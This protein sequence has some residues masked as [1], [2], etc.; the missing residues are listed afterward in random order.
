M[1]LFNRY[2][3]L[4]GLLLLFQCAALNAQTTSGY[5]VTKKIKLGGEGGWDYLT[6][7]AKGNRV[8]IS[9]STHVM[10]VDADTGAVVGDIPETAGVHGIALVQDMDKGYTS[11][12]RTS[13]VTVFDLKTL[14]VLKQIPVGKNPDAIIYDPASKRVFTMNGAGSDATAIDVKTDT[15]AGTVALDGKPEFAAADEKGHVFVNLEDKS[16]V[17][18]MDSQKLSVMNRWPLAP[19]EEPSGMAIDTKHHR[20]FIGCG[21]NKLM[22]VVDSESGKVITTLPTGSGVDANGFDPGT[23]FAF[24]SNGDG[25]LTIVHED[26]ADKFSVVDNV[27]TQRGAR[28]MT[29]DT[30]THRVFLVTADFGPPPPAT[31]ERPRPRPSVVPG[32]F[33]LLIVGK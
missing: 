32:S 1:R 9:R 19:G 2:S 22:A 30:K 14:K 17:I 7:D 16:V 4:V 24:S 12:G 33:T 5:H 15:V 29:V 25:T 8:F 31:P 23:G 27:P 28:T 13:T 18:E 20:L 10:V 6:F 11:N 21:G 3:L 26:S